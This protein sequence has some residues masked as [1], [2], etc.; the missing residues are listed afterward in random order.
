MIAARTGVIEPDIEQS[1]AYV[2]G[3]LRALRNDRKLIVSA[4]SRAQKAADWIL[5]EGER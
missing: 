5:K 1:A 3:W 2:E 4:G